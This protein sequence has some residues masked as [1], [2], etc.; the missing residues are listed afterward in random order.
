[1][2]KI[3]RNLIKISPVLV[4]GGVLFSLIYLVPRI[5]KISEIV[6]ESQFGPCEDDIKNK[7]S[8]FADLS[9]YGAKD[10]A[11][12]YLSDR[13]SISKFAMRF[14]FPDK[15]KVELIQSK[16]KSALYNGRG[17][18]ALIDKQGLVLSYQA[19]TLLPYI[20]IEDSPPSVG[21]KVEGD[22]AFALRILEY[23][24]NLFGAKEG[25]VED[26]GVVFKLAGRG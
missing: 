15:L 21:E 10:K 20:N 11:N 6:C 2:R 22:L 1:M 19:E 17:Q 3:V 5:V 13:P 8:D 24:N 23:M 12:G 7:L 14:L 25:K 18:F 26:S 4:L 9:L 16:P